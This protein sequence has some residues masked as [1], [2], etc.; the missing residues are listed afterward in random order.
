MSPSLPVGNGP[1]FWLNS[2][3]QFPSVASMAHALPVVAKTGFAW[4]I[5]RGEAPGFVPSAAPVMA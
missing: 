5:R 4:T 3:Y 2:V 1:L